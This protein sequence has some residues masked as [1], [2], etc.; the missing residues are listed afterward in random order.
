MVLV[1][2]CRYLLKFNWFEQKKV[3]FLYTKLNLRPKNCLLEIEASNLEG[4]LLK[5]QYPTCLSLTKLRFRRSFWGAE[6][7][8]TS[9]GQKVMAQN[10]Y[11]SVSGFYQFCKKNNSFALFAS[12]CFCEFCTITIIPKKIKAH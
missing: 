5:F 4:P 10:T 11:F 3:H 1:F 7:V 2:K 9:I 12:F 6:W 8:C